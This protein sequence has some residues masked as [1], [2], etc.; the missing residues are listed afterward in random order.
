ML[1]VLSRS[2]APVLTALALCWVA[3]LFMAPVLVS[4]TEP[5]PVLAAVYAA[6]GLIC[7]QRPERSFA[8]AGTQMPVCARCSGLYVAGAAGALAGFF[9]ARRVRGGSRVVRTALATAAVPTVVT[10]M[11]EW[12]ALAFPSNTVRAASALPLGAAAG[13]IFVR[14]LLE[15]PDAS[16]DMIA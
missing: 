12:S 2:I 9:V 8:I 13:W 11:L 15:A 7:H 10:L 6:A 5:S 16:R 3:I 14:L 1:D 4:R